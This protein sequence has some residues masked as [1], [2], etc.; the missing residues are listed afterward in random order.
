[1]LIILWG[2]EQIEI[3]AKPVISLGEGHTSVRVKQ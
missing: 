2:C 3:L 1:M